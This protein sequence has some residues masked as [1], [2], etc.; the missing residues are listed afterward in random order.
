MVSLSLLVCSLI[1][2]NISASRKPPGL[3]NAGRV[4]NTMSVVYTM[5]NLRAGERASGR[6]GER[7]GKLVAGARRVG[8]LWVRIERT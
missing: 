7:K 8:G 1:L 6:A 3:R 4:Q 5:E 2:E